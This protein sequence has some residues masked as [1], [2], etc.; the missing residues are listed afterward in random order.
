MVVYC[1]FVY[2]TCMYVVFVTSTVMS[3]THIVVSVAGMF[4]LALKMATCTQSVAAE[5][6]FSV[7]AVPVR[8]LYQIALPAAYLQRRTS[9]CLPSY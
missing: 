1:M 3:I 5:Q 6:P 8:C 9:E 2:T 4:V 7:V